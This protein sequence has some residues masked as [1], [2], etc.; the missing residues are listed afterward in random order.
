MLFPALNPIT[1]E[2]LE[3]SGTKTS[4]FKYSVKLSKSV[5]SLFF[6]LLYNTALSQNID[7]NDFQLNVNF[8]EKDNNIPKY[9][10]ELNDCFIVAGQAFNKDNDLI[11]NSAI[12]KLS[13][14]G[15]LI[16]KVFLGS[17]DISNRK[18]MKSVFLIKNRIVQF[19]TFRKKNRSHLWLREIDSDLNV[20]K[21][22][23]FNEF[24]VADDNDPIVLYEN[25]KGIYVITKTDDSE[26]IK[27]GIN[28]L[29]LSNNFEIIKSQYIPLIESHL[30]VR[31]VA[32]TLHK[33]SI[34][35]TA[36]VC[37]EKNNNIC[38]SEKTVL[39]DLNL[40]GGG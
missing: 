1:L 31:H 37:V 13:K 23:E 38:N 24:T 2:E 15:K 4:P 14:D 9:A 11:Y 20:I 7:K 21:E 5:I 36:F 29:Q 10:I 28:L 16:K 33:N 6:I 26:S 35:L 25:K 39:F 18:S 30:N 40:F 32:A 12:I 27:N 17:E 8:F 3:V 34:F 19:G 22:K